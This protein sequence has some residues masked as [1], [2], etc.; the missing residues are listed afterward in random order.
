VLCLQLH[1]FSLHISTWVSIWKYVQR[2]MNL[3]KIVVSGLHVSEVSADSIMRDN[4]TLSI[5]C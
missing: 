3:C 5:E 1:P 4:V 2:C